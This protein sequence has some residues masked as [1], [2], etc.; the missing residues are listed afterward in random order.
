MNE[1]G[2]RSSFLH[3]SELT[4]PARP[5]ALEIRHLKK[6][7]G[8]KPILRRVD[9]TLQQGQRMAL[10]GANGAGKTTLLRILAG[11]TRPSSG[12]VLLMGLDCVAQ[13][14]QVRRLVGV[15]AHQPYLYEELTA[16]ENLHFFGRMYAIENVQERSEFLLQRVGLHK[17]AHERVGAFSRGQLQRLAWARAL[18]HAPHLLLLDEPDTGL[19]QDGQELMQSLLA[20]HIA[21]GGSI[22]FTTHLLEDALLMSDSIAILAAGRISAQLTSAD[23]ELDELRRRYQEVVR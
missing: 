17:R 20:E 16:L 19:D 1:Q 18:L 5:A 23:V 2:E 3:Q 8:L 11:L 21:D 12:H 10:L 13:A 14:Q 15:I 4:F 6:S 7:Y 9:L 22:L